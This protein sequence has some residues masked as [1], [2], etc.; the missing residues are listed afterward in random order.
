MSEVDGA[1]MESE[2][3]G[4]LQRCHALLDRLDEALPP[5]HV[6]DFRHVPAARWVRR[7]LWGGQ[8]LPVHRP[9]VVALDALVGVEEQAQSLLRNTRR[10]LAGSPANHALLWG[11]RGT[12]KSSLVKAVCMNL[13]GLRLVEVDRV[14]LGDLP[15]ILGR[16]ADLP[17]HFVV[18]CDDLSFGFEEGGYR[19]LKVVLDG[20]LGAAG[21]RVLVYATSNRRHLVAEPLSDNQNAQRFGEEIH[22]GEASDER[23]A[24]AERFGLQLSFYPFDGQRYQEAV[25]SWLRTYGVEPDEALLQEAQRFARLRGGRSGRVANQ[26]ARAML[27]ERG[28]A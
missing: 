13:P 12:G 14:H 19:E 1:V 17:Y 21:D 18:F 20:S 24:L 26:F 8:L 6:P 10:F 3:R 28:D 11:A 27:P 16:L 4:L 25:A 2:W 7:P 5:A 22:P 23:L 15:E 9:A